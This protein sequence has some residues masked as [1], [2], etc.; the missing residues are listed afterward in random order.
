MGSDVL[1]E[2]NDRQML[3]T[4]SFALTAFDAIRG[5]AS[6]VGRKHIISSQL[7]IA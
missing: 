4:G 7:L 1:Q 2:V 6:V 3:G 5:L